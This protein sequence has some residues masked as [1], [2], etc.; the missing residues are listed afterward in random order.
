MKYLRCLMLPV[1]AGLT[2][3]IWPQEK[4]T[5]NLTM[6]EMSVPPTL[7]SSTRL[8]D[9]PSE[10]VLH[11]SVSLPY[12][13]LEGMQKFADDVSNPKSPNF[14]HFLSP[15]EVG[16]RFG[17]S[18]ANLQ[19][20]SDYLTSQGMKVTL[21]AK[22]RLTI[23]ADATVAQA[24]SAFHTTIGRFQK[25]RLSTSVT[26]SATYFSYTTPPTVPTELQPLII[27]V[28]GMENF[29][30][31]K[32]RLTPLP[33]SVIRKVYGLSTLY[34]ANNKGQGRTIAITSFDGFRLDNLPYYYTNAGLTAPAAGVGSNVSV[35][36]LSSAGGSG[37]FVGEA[38]LDIQTILGV[39]PL[40]NLVIYDGGNVSNR[41]A[42]PIGTL[43]REANDNTADI[44]SESYG[45]GFGSS[46]A[47][48]AHNIHL[49]MT[50]QGI[51]YMAATGD[52]GTDL[53]G[54]GQLSGIIYP[55][56]EP[57]VL[58]VGGTSVAVDSNGNRTAETG[59]SGSGGGWLNNAAAFNTLPSWQKGAGVPTNI[60]FRLLP[61]V[62]LNADPNSGYYV[63]LFENSPSQGGFYAIG[64]TS[65]ASPTMAGG[66]G[67]VQQKL[68][69]S[70]L[71]PADA[72]GKQRMGRIQDTL[73]GLNGDSSV[74]F[75]VTSGNNGTLPNGTTS[76]ATT[77]WDFVTGLGAMNF[78]GFFTRYSASASILS[79]VSITPTSAQGG[80]GTTVTGTV[81]LSTAA[82]TGGTRVNLTSS[83]VT[84]LAVT[85]S[86]TVP[87][88]ATSATFRLVPI[89][90]S[91]VKTVTVTATATTG[92]PV[93][94]TFTVN[95]VAVTALTVTPTTVVG[96]SSTVGTGTVTVDI[97]AADAGLT[98]AISSNNSAA[99]FPAT[100]N[101]A[102]GS[103]TATF[104]VTFKA[105]ATNSTVGIT[106]KIGTT[107]KTAN[108]TV[109]APTLS[110]VGVS[111]SGTTGLTPITGRV[112][113]SGPAPAGGLPIALSVSDPNSASVPASVTVP[114]GTNVATFSITP[115]AVDANT[116]VTIT[117][118]LGATSRTTSITVHAAIAASISVTPVNLMGGTS[119]TATVKLASPA[120]PSGATVTLSTS[121]AAVAGFSSAT[122]LVP[123]GQTTASAAVNTFAV[124]ATSTATLSATFN[125]TKVNATIT[126]QPP[127]L[128]SVTLTPA[129]VKG[130]TAVTGTVTLNGPAGPSGIVVTLTSS[131]TAVV[132]GLTSVTVPAGST[133]GTFTFTPSTVTANTNVV[134]VG[135]FGSDSK[136]AIVTVTK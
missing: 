99:I 1:I 32:P 50:A 98:V 57:E 124:S 44:I 101:I 59:W 134:I 15:E 125:G 9:A 114:A 17:V 62:A 93:S 31:P 120:G 39:A 80:A 118:T 90:T 67:V 25:K 23:L 35:V 61:D 91:A 14:R 72:S 21:T 126:V 112:I 77:G 18:K 10:Q 71:L 123:A 108:V 33:P 38:D 52:D 13:D 30:Q 109:Y 58:Q 117:A 95:P 94:T 66:L 45:F 75:D 43:T 111:T 26:D 64:G 69:A 5:S 19:R 135:K 73:Y 110:A 113:I 65:G 115:L 54:G 136:N 97:P 16:N 2:A 47:T 20:V 127:R 79:A 82:P 122:V 40:C 87:A 46:T 130:G 85:S 102:K 55:D 3:S 4:A 104:N 88:G 78:N 37:P 60:N 34:D 24:E 92:T 8:S 7:Q 119:A 27:D 48:A 116:S 105:V 6:L 22:N 129:S 76:N 51:T 56:C 84:A 106:A 81:T 83:D 74:F 121:A 70:G 96:G 107:S 28:A 12:G 128:A 132:S 41:V 100:V 131:N 68:I 11:L 42:D 36:A 103:K 133:T 63:W 89:A 49:S 53:T 29:T 86:V